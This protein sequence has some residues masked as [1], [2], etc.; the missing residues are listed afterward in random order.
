MCCAS[1]L[2]YFHSL[3]P[4]VSEKPVRTS[5]T[6]QSY[7]FGGSEMQDTGIRTMKLTTEVSVVK[8]VTLGLHFLDTQFRV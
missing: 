4:V 2:L 1:Y 6:E 7:E 3:E 5:V 8:F